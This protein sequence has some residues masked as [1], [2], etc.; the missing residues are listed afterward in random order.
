[1]EHIHLKYHGRLFDM[2]VEQNPKMVVFS[3]ARVGQGGHGH[4]AERNESEWRKEWTSRGY[5]FSEEK[6]ELLRN[7]SNKTNINHIKNLQFFEKG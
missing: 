7:N 2:F 4:I 1:M 6:T 3:A 5:V